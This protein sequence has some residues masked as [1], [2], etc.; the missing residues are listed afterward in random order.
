M[1]SAFYTSSCVSVKLTN[2]ILLSSLSVP[3]PAIA[4]KKAAPRTAFSVFILLSQCLVYAALN[5]P[6]AVYSKTNAKLEIVLRNKIVIGCA[7]L[8]VSERS[9]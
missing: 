7:A 3:Q 1:L 8:A 5:K 4:Q 6:P 9:V 2:F